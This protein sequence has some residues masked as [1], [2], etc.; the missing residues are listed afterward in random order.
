[1]LAFHALEQLP[2]QLRQ[3]GIIAAGQAGQADFL[4]ARGLFQ[5]G[6]QLHQMLQ[7]PLTNRAIQHPRLAEAAAAGTAP[8]DLQ[9]DAVVDDL[10]IGHRDI[11]GIDHAVQIGNDGLQHLLRGLGAVG[12]E[13]GDG[14]VLVV[15][16]VVQGWHV[17]APH[18]SQAP[19]Q[20]ILAR[21]GLL[22]FVDDRVQLDDLLLAVA[23]HERIDEIR[24]GLGVE[25]AGAP[26]HHDGIILP[27]LLP[28]KRNPAQLQHRQDVGVAH[29]ILQG[30]AHHVEIV[31]R[32]AA[33][34]GEQ[35]NVL[36]LHQGHHVHP[37]HADPLAQAPGLGVDGGVEDLHAQVGHGHLVGIG[38]AE[39]KVQLGL[40]P[41][42]DGSVHLAAGVSGSFLDFLQHGFNLLGI[43]RRISS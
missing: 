31:Q 38:E 8:H 15:G 37:G 27:A 13:G 36:L 41:A 40:L 11:L 19:E 33:L 29:L 16:H 18:L 17:H 32:V 6:G 20:H 9:H 21:T 7:A 39:G 5:G 3:A 35:G 24:Q 26:R 12:P 2:D 1:M 22:P 30:E 28:Q 42:L 25:G 43:Q 10:R 14:A 23:Y 4:I 34:Q